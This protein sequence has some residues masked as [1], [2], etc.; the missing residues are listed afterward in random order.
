[1]FHWLPVLL[2]GVGVPPAHTIPASKIQELPRV[3]TLAARAGNVSAQVGLQ[4][5]LSLCSGPALPCEEVL[6]THMHGLSGWILFVSTKGC[7]VSNFETYAPAIMPRLDHKQSS[8]C[9][10]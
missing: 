8:R 3:L 9:I 7:Y 5:N 10:Q 6:L 1:M 2:A 4:I